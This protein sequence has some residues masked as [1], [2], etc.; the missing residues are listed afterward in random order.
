[1]GFFGGC[2]FDGRSWLSFEPYSDR[3]PK[4]PEPWLS[5]ET[6]DSD[7][8]TVRYEP[9]GPGSGIAYL[10]YTPRAYFEDETASAPADV[11]REAA[12]LGLA[13]AG[14]GRKR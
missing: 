12:G 1:M 6:Y 10:G 11:P 13:V 14:A 2:V 5:V 9:P 7:I 8:A 4:T 3:M